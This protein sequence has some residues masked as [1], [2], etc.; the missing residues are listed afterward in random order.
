MIKNNCCFNKMKIF[1][2]FLSQVALISL[3]VITIAI[4]V[5]SPTTAHCQST[6]GT[7]WEHFIIRQPASDYNLEAVSWSN[8]RFVSVGQNNLFTSPDGFNWT[9]HNSNMM[10]APRAITRSN[11]QFV[12][13]GMRGLILTSP[14]GINWIKR[15]NPISDWNMHINDVT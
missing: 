8:D 5:I 12:L 2:K 1:F 3:V 10:V 15:D 11:N 6:P 9:K 14:D 7:T 13:G 4:A